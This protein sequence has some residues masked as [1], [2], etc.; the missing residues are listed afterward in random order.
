MERIHKR[1]TSAE[2]MR[3]LKAR[4]DQERAE[5]L[6][7]NARL[8]AAMREIRDVANNI[9]EARYIASNAVRD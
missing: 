8:L 6:A 2:R 3:A 9:Q 1:S 7:T 5:L 4:R